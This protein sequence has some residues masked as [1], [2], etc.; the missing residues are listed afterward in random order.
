M[1]NGVLTKRNLA[2]CRTVTRGR[3]EF[4]LG[5]EEKMKSFESVMCIAL[6]QS[7]AGHVSGEKMSC[8]GCLTSFS[9]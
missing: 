5:R 4:T 1:N 7:A 3:K 8:T 9:F 6:S 2:I